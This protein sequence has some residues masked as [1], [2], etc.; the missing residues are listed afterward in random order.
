MVACLVVVGP[1][2]SGNWFTLGGALSFAGLLHAASTA[3]WIRLTAL[4]S[5]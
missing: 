5:L 4:L 3:C 1:M 2:I